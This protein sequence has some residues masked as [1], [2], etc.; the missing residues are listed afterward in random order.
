M[1]YPGSA[2]LASRLSVMDLS[3]LG[4]RLGLV[5]LSLVAAACDQAVEGEPSEPGCSGGASAGTGG[6]GGAM[7]TGGTGGSGGTSGSGGSSGSGAPGGAGASAGTGG[8]GGGAGGSSS[9][10]GGAMTTGGTGGSGGTSGTAGTAGDGA[11]GATAG[12]GG[13]AGAGTSGDGG[14]GPAAGT[15]GGAGAPQGGSAGS[16]G[17]PPGS[18]P[19]DPSLLSS[20]TGT[21]P[22]R[23]TIQAP[24]GNHDVTVELGDAMTT[25]SS[26]VDVETRHRVVDV[27]PTAAGAYAS[28]TFTANVRQ[29]QH[30]GGQSAPGNVLDVTIGGT[31]PKLHGI[32]VRAAPTSVTLFFAGD[33]TACDWVATNSSALRDDETGWA[34]VLSDHFGP[35]VAIANYADSGETAGGFYGKFFG[36]ARTAMKAGDYLFI[37]FG[38]NDQKN[39]ADVD[40][41]KANL[42][43]YVNDARA[44]NATPVILSPVSR[45]GGSSGNPGFAGLD[46]QARDLAAAENVALIDLTALSRTYYASVPD[47]AALFVD[48]GTHFSEVG[49]FGVA[50]VVADAIDAGSLPLKTFLK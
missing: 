21:N 15:G 5:S 43:K 25:G 9:G 23:C 48:S 24:N 45:S 14:T 3:R 39:T 19:L 2:I 37:Q 16:G 38:H 1:R 12:A 6:T 27:T 32:G 36:P 11:G 8:S 44:K 35:G 31:Q 42:M 18:V 10:T 46:Q 30:D 13:D 50:T 41:Y 33:S 34:Q 28:F 47:K 4:V 17:A 26:W 49:A 20:C 7:T 29:E 40:A 22:I